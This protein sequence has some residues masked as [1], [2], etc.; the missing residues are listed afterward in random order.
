[1]SGQ[2]PVDDTLTVTLSL[3]GETDPLRFGDVFELRDQLRL[4]LKW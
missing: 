2:P 3:S 4:W 1:M